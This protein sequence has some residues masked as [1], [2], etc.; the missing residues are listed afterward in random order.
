MKSINWAS[1]IATEDAAE[2]KATLR[3]R[4]SD[5]KRYKPQYRGLNYIAESVSKQ[6]RTL[7]NGNSEILALTP[8]L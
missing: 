5:R 3:T 8:A 2:V 4:L 6:R 1:R 7:G